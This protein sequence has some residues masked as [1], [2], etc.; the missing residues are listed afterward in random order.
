MKAPIGERSERTYQIHT[1]PVR[2]DEDTI[3]IGMAVAQDVTDQRYAEE[4]IRWQA[5][6]DVLTRLPNRALLRD[7]LDRVLAMSE[8]SGEIVALLFLDLN[9][10][11]Q[12][13]DTLGHAVGDRLLETLAARLTGCL[14]AADTVARMGGDEFVVLLPSLQAAVDAAGVANKVMETLAVPIA[15]DDVQLSVTV[16]VGISVFPFDGRDSASLLESADA[17]MYRAKAGHH[18]GRGGHPEMGAGGSTVV[19]AAD[20]SWSAS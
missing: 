10:F 16:S 7:R 8:R 2:D 20:G 4:I 6:H 5:H 13:N 3:L 1:L 14:R 18:A 17:A 9:G 12:V 15:L 19:Q 11:K